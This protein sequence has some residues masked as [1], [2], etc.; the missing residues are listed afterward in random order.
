MQM[1]VHKIQDMW[2]KKNVINQY[3]TKSAI[4][5]FILQNQHD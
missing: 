2:V 4:S 5:V 3:Q 1:N